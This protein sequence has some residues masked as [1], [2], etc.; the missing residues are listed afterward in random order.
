MAKQQSTTK[1][2]ELATAATFNIATFKQEQVPSAI[3]FLEAKIKELKGDDKGETVITGELPGFGRIENITDVMVLR[4][5]Y[6]QVTQKASVIN[7]HNDV[8]QAVAPSIKVAK[9]KEGGYSP[10]QWQKGILSQYK[11]IVFKEELEKLEKAKDKLQ[12][13][14]SEEERM[15]QDLKDVFAL[16]GQDAE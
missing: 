5:A 11:K 3:E 12:K 16:M 2:T 10:E 4:A 15:K 6:A 1:A 13:H 7:A 9:Y 8:F 14:L